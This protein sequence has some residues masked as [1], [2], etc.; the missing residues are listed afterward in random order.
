MKHLKNFSL[1]EDFLRSFYESHFPTKRDNINQIVLKS[2]FLAGTILLVIFF[3]FIAIYFTNV[4]SEQT[5]ISQTKE[6]YQQ[7][8]SNKETNKEAL[9]YFSKQNSDLKGWI[10]IDGTSLCNPIYQTDNNYYYLYSI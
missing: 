1:W 6:T 8:T 2:V 3:C 9:E 4:N 7:L 5:L 10:S